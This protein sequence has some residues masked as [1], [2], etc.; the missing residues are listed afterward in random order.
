MFGDC[1][2]F[3]IDGTVFAFN[4]H[5]SQVKTR[6]VRKLY[7]LQHQR[8]TSCLPGES[9]SSKGPRRAEIVPAASSVAQVVRAW[10]TRVE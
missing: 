6:D 4:K 2:S 7:Q 9:R 10:S 8:H 1:T 5:P 3:S